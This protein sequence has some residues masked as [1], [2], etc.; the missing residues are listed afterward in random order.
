MKGDL[1]SFSKLGVLFALGGWLFGQYPIGGWSHSAF[2]VV[3]AFVPPIIFAFALK[4]P[5]SQTQL[6]IAA[7]CA[8]LAENTVGT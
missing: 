8:V 2:H 6:Y 3:M 5:A 1:L 4:L 7:Q